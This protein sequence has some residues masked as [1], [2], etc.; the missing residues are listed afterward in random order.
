V[1]GALIAASSFALART[2]NAGTGRLIGVFGLSLIGAGVFV[3]DPMPHD[4]ATGHG[5]AHTVFSFV[6][7]GSLAAACF[8]AA[9]WRPAPRWRRYC[10]LTGAAVP[11]LF[12]V[13]GGVAGTSGLWQRLAIVIGWSWLVMLGLRAMRFA[14]EPAAEHRYH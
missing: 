4:Q 6:T 14:R 9:R 13:A 11:V 7:F 12:V 2:V 3:S 10:R 8:T 5:I 1:S